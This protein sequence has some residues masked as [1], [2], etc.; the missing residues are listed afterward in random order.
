MNHIYEICK[1]DF[2]SYIFVSCSDF[3]VRNMERIR[4]IFSSLTVSF[5][6]HN[7]SVYPLIYFYCFLFPLICKCT[8]TQTEN[9]STRANLR[10]LCIDLLMKFAISDLIV[11]NNFLNVS[12]YNN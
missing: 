2:F 12:R 3:F 9:W 5:T 11:S 4:L 6:I 8:Q 10:I 7:L 1:Q